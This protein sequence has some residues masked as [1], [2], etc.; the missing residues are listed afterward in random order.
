MIKLS[1]KTALA[2]LAFMAVGST[3]SA[4]GWP[5]DWTKATTPYRIVGNVYYVGSEG[6][7][8]YLISSSQ[9]HI[10]IDGGMPEG[11][12]LIEASIR[13]LGFKVE[14]VKILL[15]T[16]AHIDH[17]GGLAQ[18]K[19][20]TK[21]RLYASK[22]DEESLE[23]GVHVGDNDNGAV[24]Y[25]AVKVDRTVK[26]LQTVKLGE[27][28]IT[29]HL[30]PGHTTGCTTWTLPVVERERALN[31]TF[32]CSTT[33]AGNVLIG[34]RAHPRIVD[35]Y[36]AS[37]AKLR[38]IPTDV[39]LPNHPGFADLAGKRQRLLRGEPNPYIDPTEM[40]RFVD[41]SAKAFEQELAKQENRR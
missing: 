5:A 6:I 11:A 8:S 34:N 15:N 40:A 24:A 3:A 41:A 20:D 16:H 9:G 23:K 28:A 10:V 18:L 30:T 13:K 19:A 17:A 14:D 2:A 22:A 25:P 1:K 36:R 21:A 38:M 37:F 35:D 32:Y 39:F 33:V 27:V 4:Q 31:V 26:D 29:A 12:P 7:A